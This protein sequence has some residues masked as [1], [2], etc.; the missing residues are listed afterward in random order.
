MFFFALLKERNDARAF[1]SS[2][3]LLPLS[4][5]MEAWVIELATELYQQ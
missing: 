3:N 2:V 4:G 5:L 1:H